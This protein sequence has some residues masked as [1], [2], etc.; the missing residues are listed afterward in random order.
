MFLGAVA[1]FLIVKFHWHS[2][3]N[4]QTSNRYFN[5]TNTSKSSSWA[6]LIMSNVYKKWQLTKYVCF[7][8]WSTTQ[9]TTE[10]ECESDSSF[11][12]GIEMKVKRNCYFLMFSGLQVLE[13]IYVLMILFF[14]TNSVEDSKIYDC[15]YLLYRIWTMMT[16]RLQHWVCI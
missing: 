13:S 3:Q 14:F 12:K 2:C 4:Q 7:L 10:W 6:H 8:W 9:S 1:I 16:W 11:K 15:K 5:I